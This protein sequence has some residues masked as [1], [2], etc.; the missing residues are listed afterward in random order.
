MSRKPA[1]DRFTRFTS[2]TPSA[3]SSKPPTSFNSSQ[4]TQNPQQPSPSSTETP[5]ERV[6]RLRAEHLRKRAAEFSNTDRVLASGRRVADV[7]HRGA[8]YTLLGFSALATVFAAY[9]LVSLVSHNRTQKR[10]WIER[11]MDRLESA[12]A[13]FLKGTADAEQLHLLEQER[14][15]EEIRNK[16]EEDK[17]RRKQEGWFSNVKKMFR[18][19]A[20]AGDM[21]ANPSEPTLRERAERLREA[22]FAEPQQM[23]TIQTNSGEV[24]MRPAAVAETSVPGVGL[25]EKG[26]PVP[27]GKVERVTTERES[28]I[29]AAVQ[30]GTR[31][32]G[33]LDVL[34]Q[35]ATSASS[36]WLSSVFGR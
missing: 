32:P 23:R 29:L 14:A 36:N 28:P 34:A 25:D 26:R 33:E 35:N 31:R 20:Q 16:Y 18:S 30:A 2:T 24:T 6:A 1:N 21:G 13:A 10:A 5:Q 12:R 7:L 15:G 9:G 19:G 8:T 17:K 4:P 11:E 3:S 27:L 22:E